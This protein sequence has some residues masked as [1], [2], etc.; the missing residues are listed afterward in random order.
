MER[1]EGFF[2]TSRGRLDRESIED[3]E[4]EGNRDGS[5]GL[6]KPTNPAQSGEGFDPLRG[7]G[8]GEGHARCIGGRKVLLDE[9]QGP[10]IACPKPL[11]Q[12]GHR[13][14]LAEDFAVGSARRRVAGPAAEE[15][16]LDTKDRCREAHGH[17]Q[18]ARDLPVHATP[19]R[20]NCLPASLESYWKSPHGSVTD[21]RPG[22]TVRSSARRGRSEMTTSIGWVDPENPRSRAGPVGLPIGATS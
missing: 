9:D 21:N 4:G 17:H 3:L 20:H 11:D 7:F 15:A 12:V 18:D 1:P 2:P 6:F 13:A 14:L 22:F 10:G 16:N 5:H 19:L 8:V